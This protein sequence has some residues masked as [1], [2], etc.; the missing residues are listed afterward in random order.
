MPFQICK[1]ICKILKNLMCNEEKLKMCKFPLT[2]CQQIV[3]KTC[4]IRFLMPQAFQKSKSY[5]NLTTESGSKQRFSLL[6]ENIVIQAVCLR[7][8]AVSIKARFLGIKDRRLWVFRKSQKIPTA[9]DQYFY[10]I[11]LKNCK[12]PVF[13][14]CI[15]YNVLAKLSLIVSITIY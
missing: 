8:Q 12:D 5:Q 2:G 14:Q 7:A 11:K 9:S 10:Q 6:Q 1:N 3:C 4:A 15:S 13:D